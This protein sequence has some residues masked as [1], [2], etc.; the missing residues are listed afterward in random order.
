[1]KRNVYRIAILVAAMICFS[2]AALGL[3]S[4]V[5]QQETL[6]TSKPAEQC[7]L[8]R[9][10]KELIDIQLRVNRY[11]MQVIEGLFEILSMNDVSAETG[12]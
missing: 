9:I 4:D 8:Y 1:M 11:H 3:E 7:L 5:N 10:G 6:S 2:T 12:E